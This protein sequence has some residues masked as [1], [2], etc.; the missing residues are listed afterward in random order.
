M[1]TEWEVVISQASY[2]AYAAVMVGLGVKYLIFPKNGCLWPHPA[3]WAPNSRLWIIGIFDGANIYPCGYIF[4][5]FLPAAARL[6]LW[7]KWSFMNVSVIYSHSIVA[8]YHLQTLRNG[9]RRVLVTFNDQSTPFS[10]C[11]PTP[12]SSL[13]H[14]EATPTKS[15]TPTYHRAVVPHSSLKQLHFL[16]QR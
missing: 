10:Y 14:K 3:H 8:H 15:G 11:K 13:V 7:V 12:I 16:P 6:S 2:R 1:R 9:G 5:F 4:F